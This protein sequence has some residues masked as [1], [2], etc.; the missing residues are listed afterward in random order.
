[1]TP[2][3]LTHWHWQGS[4]LRSNADVIWPLRGLGLMLVSY[5]AV[6]AAENAGWLEILYFAVMV[7]AATLCAGSPYRGVHGQK[8][9]P[10]W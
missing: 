2:L 1:M 6:G 9:G 4:A 3:L 5:S 10:A 7:A 8:N